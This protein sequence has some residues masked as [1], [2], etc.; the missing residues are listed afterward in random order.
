MRDK[1]TERGCHETDQLRNDLIKDHWM[2]NYSWR[3]VKLEYLEKGYGVPAADILTILRDIAQKY[4]PPDVAKLPN[5]RCESCGMRIFWGKLN[6]GSHPFDP[7]ILVVGTDAGKI[8]RGRESHF[9]S[10]PNAK[11]HR[12]SS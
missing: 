6:G 9:V 11:A 2:W 3:G 7:K 1:L 4:D 5:S 8:E 10:C 12:K